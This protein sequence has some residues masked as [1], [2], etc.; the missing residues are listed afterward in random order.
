MCRQEMPFKKRNS[1]DD[2]FEAVEAFGKDY[3]PKEHEA[4][5]LAL[6]PECAAKYKEYVKKDRAAR[7]VLYNLLK[8]SDESEVRLELNDLAICIWFNEKHWHDLKTVLHYYG[9]SKSVCMG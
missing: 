5:H 8:D 7:K 6:C 3:F 9:R 1:D 4:Q 2:Y